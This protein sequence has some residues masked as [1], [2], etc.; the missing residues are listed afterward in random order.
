[1]KRTTHMALIAVT[2]TSA[3]MAAWAATAPLNDALSSASAQV[4]ITQ[5]ISTAEQ[6]GGGKASRAEFERTK[7]GSA[8]DIEV[9]AGTKTFDVRIH[10]DTGQVLASAEDKS[11]NDDNDKE[12]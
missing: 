1:M 5:A 7:D 3:A 8:Y 10:A 4:S 9:I 2:L 11:D 12:D 6:H